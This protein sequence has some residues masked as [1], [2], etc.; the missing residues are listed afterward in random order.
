MVSS[1]AALRAPLHLGLGWVFFTF[2]PFLFRFVVDGQEEPKITFMVHP[3]KARSPASGKHY[4]GHEYFSSCQYPPY[5]VRRRA[6]LELPA[7]YS[8]SRF[9]I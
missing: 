8:D 1:A 3:V 9:G 6:R 2:L 4:S 5:S 7:T